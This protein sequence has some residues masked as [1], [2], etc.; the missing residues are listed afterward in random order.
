MRNDKNP[1]K[2]SAIVKTFA[3]LIVASVFE[4]FF[5]YSGKIKITLESHRHI[6]DFITWDHFL[7]IADINVLT[8]LR[9]P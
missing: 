5:W 4:A 9:K 3:Q 6:C 2:Y 7:D 8:R 1:S